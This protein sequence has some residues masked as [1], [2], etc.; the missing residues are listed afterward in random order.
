MM[1]LFLNTSK[2]F[3]KMFNCASLDVDLF[4]FILIM[5]TVHRSV[6]QINFFEILPG[7]KLK[8][9]LKKSVL[10]T[11]HINSLLFLCIV[12]RTRELKISHHRGDTKL[13]D[14]EEI[15][16][17]A[18]LVSHCRKS[19]ACFSFQ[20]K[21]KE[22]RKW[23]NFQ[24]ILVPSEGIYILFHQPWNGKRNSL[25]LLCHIWPGRERVKNSCRCLCKWD[26]LWG[27]SGVYQESVRGSIRSLP[28]VMSGLLLWGLV[29]NGL[30]VLSGVYQRSVSGL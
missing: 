28:V 14:W 2:W 21:N 15:G 4:V 23:Q 17:I 5:S 1:W 26:P 9:K 18:S 25:I 11:H 20:W 30:V 10:Q 7:M 24:L 16:K 13:L 27:L 19:S 6:V 12:S 8:T 22:K 3:K 29:R